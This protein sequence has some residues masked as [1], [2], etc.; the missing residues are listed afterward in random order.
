ME[1]C[2]CGT[3]CLPCLFGQTRSK[4]GLGNC[5]VGA[6]MLI[7]PILL[8]Q[9]IVDAVVLGP[10]F[11]L[12]SCIA[13][14]QSAISA[15]FNSGLCS[16]IALQSCPVATQLCPELLTAGENMWL[17]Y[18]LN[19]VLVLILCVVSWPRVIHF[20]VRVLFPRW[21]MTDACA[22]MLRTRRSSAGTAPS[23]NISWAC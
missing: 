21:C 5:F 16:E 9:I 13:E 12:Q 7:A 2:L 19:L 1:V 6:C 11:K 22:W 3:F 8:V 10:V 20:C 4:A 18:A 14:H 23:C 17:I 15:A